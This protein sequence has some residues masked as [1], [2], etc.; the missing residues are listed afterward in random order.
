MNFVHWQN[1]T[2]QCATIVSKN[3]VRAREAFQKNNTFGF[4]FCLMKH[5]NTN[6]LFMEKTENHIGGI[7]LEVR[8]KI[9]PHPLI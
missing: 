3:Q 1:Y 2:L 5:R 6:Y 4:S 8:I 9:N 7:S